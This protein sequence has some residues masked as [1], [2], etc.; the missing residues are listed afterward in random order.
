M[1]LTI[2]QTCKC[3]AG[4]AVP[5][6]AYPLIHAFTERHEYC[7]TATSNDADED[8]DHGPGGDVFAQAERGREHTEP[9]LVT[10]FQRQAWV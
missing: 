9:E 1:T 2:S 10:G 7:I 3:G 5:V 8:D 6:F 4:I